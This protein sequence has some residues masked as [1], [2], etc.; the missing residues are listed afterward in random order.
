MYTS[1][2]YKQNSLS[3]YNY[4]NFG[5]GFASPSFGSWYPSY[6]G[7]DIFFADLDENLLGMTN[8]KRI[9]VKEGMSKELKEFVLMHEEE[10]VKD[11]DA[12]ELEIDNRA[13]KRFLAKHKA[14]SKEIKELVEK[15]WNALAKK[16]I[17]DLYE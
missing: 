8:G 12:S 2:N 11:M 15:R 6:L 14:I 16:M 1:N 10:H 4:R 7:V 5:T 3:R 9:L 17:D 13:L